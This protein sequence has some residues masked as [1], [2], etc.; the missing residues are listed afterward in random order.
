ME[1]P[2]AVRERVHALVDKDNDRFAAKE[3]DDVSRAKEY[4]SLVLLV[5]NARVLG[6]AGLFHMHANH[7]DDLHAVF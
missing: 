4:G 7:G 1:D 2:T 5:A 6:S 3:L